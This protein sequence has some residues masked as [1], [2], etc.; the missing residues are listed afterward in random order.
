MRSVRPI[1]L[2]G[3]HG[4]ITSR[5]LI[6][7]ALLAASAS[8]TGA[9]VASAAVSSPDNKA[10]SHTAQGR[11][12]DSIKRLPD[13][14]GVWVLSDESFAEALSA[15]GTGAR[16]RVPVPLTPRYQT[17]LD[18]NVDKLAS[19]ETKCIPVGIPESMSIPIGHEYLFTPGRVTAVFEN[20]I[21]RHID[22]SGRPHPADRDLTSTFAG[23]SIGHWE[24]RTLVVDTI[25]ITSQAEFLIG[26]RVTDKTHL[27]ER[28]FRKNADT[29][30]IDAVIQDSEIFTKP[31]EYTRIYKHSQVPM[32][33][34]YP[35][36]EGTRDT[37]V[38]GVQSGV[39][40]TPPQPVGKP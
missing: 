33:E 37:L 27:T 30:E 4:K 16:A 32:L 24:G 9:D 25:G 1:L 18:A 23:N 29:L 7:A 20:G 3:V 40:V 10:A 12:W 26:L 36:V 38:N 6:V 13:W 19:N 2:C 15:V 8:A 11:T 22:T 34:Y 14:S 31:Y 35:C 28:I 17:M 39:D 21:V 5:L